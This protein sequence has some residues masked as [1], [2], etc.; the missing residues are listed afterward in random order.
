ESAIAQ[1]RLDLRDLAKFRSE[2]DAK[3]HS[4]PEAVG[5]YTHIVEDMIKV[6]GHVTQHSKTEVVTSRMLPLLA[7][8]IAKEHGGLERAV[9]AVLLNQAAGDG[10]QMATFKRY[11]T[12]LAG[13]K[14]ALNEF[15]ATASKEYLEWFDT[16]VTG[17]TVDQVTQIRS[18]LDAIIETN[19]PQGIAGAE[20]FAIATERLNLFKQLEDRIV[21]DIEVSA[22]EGYEAQMLEAYIIFGLG[23]LAV[24]TSVYFAFGA[25]RGFSAGFRKISD[26]IERLGNGDLSEGAKLGSASDIRYLRE[27]LND[28]RLTMKSV[29][30]H[31]NEMARGDLSRVIVP[32]SDQDE[33]AISLERMR[34]SLDA[35][36]L[37]SGNMVTAISIGS[38]QMN[39]ISNGLNDA[40]QT[41]AAASEELKRTVELIG[42]SVKAMAGNA[43]E[44]ERIASEAAA[45]AE[46][47]GEAVRSA[48][49]AM[50]TINEQ[51]SIVQELAR[52]TD[53][54]AL[55]AAVEAARAGEHGRGFAVVAAEV[56]K[57]AERSSAAAEQI[58]TL[59]QE[60]STLSHNAGTLLDDLVPNIKHTSTLVQ[61]IVETM[62]QQLLSFDEI[63][64]ALVDL[65]RTIQ[66]NA[67]ESKASSE[68]A[69][70]L[71][72]N[73][74]ALE[75]MFGFFDQSAAQGSHTDGL[76]DDNFNQAA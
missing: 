28:L 14:I 24:L 16:M 27:R 42:D 37:E 3:A 35:M 19:D 12:E 47:S 67:A 49:T 17:P 48:V 45:D 43:T 74:Q 15:E 64:T 44:T 21:T 1:L 50:A 33:M 57:L 68:A 11:L 62:N 60:T 41:Q 40:T 61:D 39:E 46:K 26:D 53:L 25:L 69:E 20:W 56:R 52:Q 5:F 7:L 18:V 31:A 51:V 36:A 59:S 58:S 4:V 9:G 34:S 6:I 54:L 22:Q 72:D 75:Q 66:R 71:S 55:N 76:H 32:L 13:E 29:A 10:V 73:S 65:N 70:S 63:E 38:E 23:V 2:V 30:A 8:I